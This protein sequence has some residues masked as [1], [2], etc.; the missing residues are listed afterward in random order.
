MTNEKIK[1]LLKGAKERQK[2]EKKIE[3]K[4]REVLAAKT[5]CNKLEKELETLVENYKKTTLR[6]SNAKF[7]IF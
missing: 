1:N 2:I 4:Q 7:I 5:K 3:V 6:M